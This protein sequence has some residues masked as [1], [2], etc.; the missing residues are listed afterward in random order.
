MLFVLF[1][2]SSIVS[3]VNR[4]FCISSRVGCEVQKKMKANTVVNDKTKEN[5]LDVYVFLKLF[6]NFLSRLCQLC[7][8]R[9]H[10]LRDSCFDRAVFN[11]RKPRALRYR[12]FQSLVLSDAQSFNVLCRL[13]RS[14]AN[15]NTPIG[16]FIKTSLTLYRFN[17]S[18]FVPSQ[19]NGKVSKNEPEKSPTTVTEDDVKSVPYHH[20]VRK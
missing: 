19:S 18:Q 3:F 20:L 16:V 11:G 9:R 15:E 4:I 2:S 8:L 6:F 17:H 14:S 5:P 10:M 12:N 1:T 13:I 7:L